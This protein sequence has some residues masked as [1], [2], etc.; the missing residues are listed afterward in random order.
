MDAVIQQEDGSPS[1]IGNNGGASVSG[2]G[3]VR[4]SA[5]VAGTPLAGTRIRTPHQVQGVGMTGNLSEVMQFM[6]MR[7]EANLL[8]IK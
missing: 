3:P 6:I 1:N 8:S 2:S 4:G 5:S 7:G